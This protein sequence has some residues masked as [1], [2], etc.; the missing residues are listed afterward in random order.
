MIVIISSRIYVGLAGNGAMCTSLSAGMILVA[1]GE[2]ISI[3]IYFT[4]S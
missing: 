3:F 4:F 2:C 1:I